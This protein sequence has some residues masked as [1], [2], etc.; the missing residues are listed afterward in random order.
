MNVNVDTLSRNPIDDNK[1]KSKYLQVDDNDTFMTSQEK[2]ISK[3]T[4]TR[5]KQENSKNEVRPSKRRNLNQGIVSDDVDYFSEIPEAQI[6]NI[7]TKVPE[8][9]QESLSQESFSEIGKNIFKYANLSKNMA[10]RLNFIK[11]NVLQKIRKFIMENYYYKSS[12]GNT[13]RKSQK[14]GSK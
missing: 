14:F 9:L 12:K 11:S 1:E 8:F 5:N 10:S 13:T 2:T 6:L 7:D 3:K 4:F